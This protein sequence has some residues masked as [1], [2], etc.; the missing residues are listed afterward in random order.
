MDQM[1]AP[2]KLN[3]R[4]R[5]LC[6][7]TGVVLTVLALA[8]TGCSMAPGASTLDKGVTATTVPASGGATKNDAPP[9]PPTAAEQ[10]AASVQKSLA[11]MASTTKAPNR[12]QILAAMLAAGAVKETV[13]ISIDVTPTGL[14]VDAM[15]TAAAVGNEC[16]VAQV[17]E[18]KAAVTILPKL[19]SG[20]CFVGDQR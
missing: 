7:A 18:G 4:N 1:S 8:M 15:E 3:R 12:A 19:A 20:Y 11:D 14:A 6:A 9:A 2:K 5:G 16:V 13:E 17:R 10:L